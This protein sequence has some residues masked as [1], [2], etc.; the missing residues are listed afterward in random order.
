ME[1]SFY[2]S[3]Y[4]RGPTWRK[5]AGLV[6]R[7]LSRVADA[8]RS[9]R[10][11]VVVVQREAGLLGPPYFETLSASVFHRPIVFD[12]DD[13]VFL[14]AQ[15]SARSQ[16]PLLHRL[17]YDG[18]KAEK[19]A[20]M[21]S[22]VVVASKHAKPWAERYCE[23]VSV[24]PTVVDGSVFHPIDRPQPD[25]RG[26][27]VGWV[28]SGSTTRLLEVAA[29]ALQRL[30]SEVPFRLRLTGALPDY[31]IPGVPIEHV[32]WDLSTETYEFARI[33]VGLHPQT[34]EAWTRHKPGFKA[35][36]YMA[37]GVAQVGSPI[38]DV[39]DFFPDGEAGFFARND[40]E[41][42]THLRTLV[43]N[44]ALRARMGDTARAAFEAGRNLQTETLALAEVLTRAAGR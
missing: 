3:A 29:P 11:D 12:L 33:D 38:G 35:H 17:V 22:E 18:G 25:E 16:N 7:S 15:E 1:E 44:A 34:D 4:Q 5:A 43:T 41:W 32:K 36:M 10:Y 37:C 24:I 27:I 8:A 23:R 2:H 28:G 30:A 21:A 13:P 19:I 40:D 26:P 31:R 6:R 20:R 39:V 9:R 42:Y 14:N